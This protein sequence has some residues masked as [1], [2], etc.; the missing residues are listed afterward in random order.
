MLIRASDNGGDRS[1]EVL[2]MEKKNNIASTSTD[3]IT[4]SSI[5]G[6]SDK[7]KP[8][9]ISPPINFY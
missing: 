3:E 9:I 4:V 7:H 8:K 1:V 2:G 6:C 5:I